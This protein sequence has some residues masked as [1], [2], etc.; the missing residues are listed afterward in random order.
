M[1]DAYTWLVL[2]FFVVVVNCC[3]A[4]FVK[5]IPVHIILFTAL[6]VGMEL[7][8]NIQAEWGSENEDRATTLAMWQ[9]L[10]SRDPPRSDSP[11]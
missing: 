7:N 10:P 6:H 4:A 5:Y 3:S 11:T 1:D 9:Q 8:V 2:F